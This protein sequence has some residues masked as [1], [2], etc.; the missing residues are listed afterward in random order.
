MGHPQF[1]RRANEVERLDDDTLPALVEDMLETMNACDG[2]GLAAPQID[3]P[4]CIIVFGVDENPRYPDAAPVPRTVLMN[5]EIAP[6]GQAVRSEWE[7]CLSLPGMRGLV[8]RYERI[9]YRGLDADGREVEGKA[10]GF[11]ARI[12]QHECDHLDG[13]LYPDR[14]EERE[15]FGFIE[16]LQ[17]AGLIP[18]ALPREYPRKTPIR[19]ASESS[20]VAPSLPARQP[21]APPAALRP[22]ARALPASRPRIRGTSRINDPAQSGR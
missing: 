14:I 10:E 9:H 21:S 20:A 15:M 16:E 18:G 7:G 4:L 2:V 3:V 22:V 12:I 8:P 6:A 19:R 13:I 11:H 1:R 5:P 17:A